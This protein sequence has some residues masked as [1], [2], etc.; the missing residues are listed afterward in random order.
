MYACYHTE[1]LPTALLAMPPNVCVT[2]ISRLVA[3]PKQSETAATTMAQ[4][5]QALCLPAHLLHCS[6]PLK[7]NRQPPLSMAASLARFWQVP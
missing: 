5:L 4:T 6:K 3:A 7:A 2:L 1:V